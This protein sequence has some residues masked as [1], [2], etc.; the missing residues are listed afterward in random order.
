M[1]SK[2]QHVIY[3]MTLL[4][5]LEE[6]VPSDHPLRRLDEALDLSF[7]DEA[8]REYYCPNNGRP[9]IDPEVLMRL[10]VLQ[11][12][13]GIDSV[14]EL[15]RQVRMNLAYLWFIGY[16]VGEP[17]PDHS[18]LSRAL[19]RFGD[20]V[21]N[22]LFAQSIAQC[23]DAGLIDGRVLHVDTTTIRADLDKNR[24]GRPDSPDPD[25]RFGR[26]PGGR[27]EPGYK[28]Q[29][30]VDGASRVVVGVA[31]MPADRTDHEG[32]VAV[33]DEAI[34]RVG[35]APQAVCAD[36]AYA[37]GPNGAAMEARG[38]RLV[39]PPPKV[40][41]P[42]RGQELF[43]IEEFIYD[44][45]RDVFVCPAGV[46]L[47][48]K[49]SM[50]GRPERRRYRARASD[51]GGCALKARCTKSPQRN[52]TASVHHA[53]LVRLRA[54]SRTASF[55]QLYRTRAPAMEGVFAEEKEWHGLRRAWR[56][57][58]SNMLIQ[59]HLIAAVLN[60]KRLAAPRKLYRGVEVMARTVQWVT[61]RVIGLMGAHS[62]ILGTFW[63]SL[64]TTT[65]FFL[66]RTAAATK[67]A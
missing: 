31:V 30:V 43:T 33:V 67:A 15:M 14:R 6:L 26:F 18:T 29:T 35:A 44:A 7:V 12:L 49:G 46:T 16:E 3:Q 22:A 59:R 48:N 42:T 37:N 34:A 21:F 57:G 40:G 60:F 23:V 61:A 51:C 2:R 19:D 1:Q 5:A 41:R 27:K 11:A 65:R 62:R 56:R 52:V 24:V 4:P 54:D 32:A 38:I 28:Q 9:G 50:S 64:D 58:L 13:E 66:V 53:A 63:H 55:K 20:E 8:V 25:A 39:S 47:T 36:A 45:R 10:F 17:L